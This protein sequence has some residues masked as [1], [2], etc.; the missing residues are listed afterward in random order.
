MNLL[1]WYERYAAEV[2]AADPADWNSDLPLTLSNG[3]PNDYDT[4]WPDVTGDDSGFWDEMAGQEVEVKSVRHV[5]TP[6]GVRQYHQ[7][8]GSVIVPHPDLTPELTQAQRRI[9]AIRERRSRSGGGAS[10]RGT[11]GTKDVWDL[12]GAKPDTH[13]PPPPDPAT[14]DEA[15]ISAWFNRDFGEM[16]GRKMN[17]ASTVK[18]DPHDPDIIKV[19]GT[20]W[21]FQRGGQPETLEF[22]SFTRD[23]NTKT[24]TVVHDSMEVN[25]RYQGRG[26]ADRFLKESEDRYREAGFREIKLTAAMD[27]GGYAWARAGFDWDPMNWVDG[28]A[29]DSGPPWDDMNAGDRRSIQQRV[30]R[31][32]HNQPPKMRQQ[33]N[34]RTYQMEEMYPGARP[35]TEKERG[36]LQ[37]VA[38]RFDQ[39][40]EEHDVSLAPTPAEIAGFADAEGIDK[41]GK[42]L[43]LGTYWP[44]RRLLVVG[45]EAKSQDDEARARWLRR[46]GRLDH[47]A[48]QWWQE[49]QAKVEEG[50]QLGED[51]LD[52]KGGE[53]G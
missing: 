36:W 21:N 28:Q 47:A 20:I 1:D 17:M 8:I 19:S 32:L 16:D 18:R 34:P 48:A 15:D 25:V 44:A 51:G 42:E 7:P 13:T 45:N 4:N 29:G 50:G 52:W 26:I 38:D 30:A 37:G 9:V 14:L 23:L 5:R 2:T 35:L 27:V 46:I 40:Y 10:G 6:E 43:L 31:L 53:S 24:R 11:S 49:V 22:A 41:L 39:A 12:L 3:K 33:V